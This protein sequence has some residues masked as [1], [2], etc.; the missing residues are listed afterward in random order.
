VRTVTPA[1]RKV[2][3]LYDNWVGPAW[4][5][6]ERTASL[7][8]LRQGTLGGRVA[9]HAPLAYT[10]DD[11]EFVLSQPAGYIEMNDGTVLLDGIA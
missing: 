4:A 8:P 3:V 7:P 5:D 9:V 2:E 10:T 11:Q 1:E 6:A